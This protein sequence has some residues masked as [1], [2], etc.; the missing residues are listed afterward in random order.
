MSALPEL[1]RPAQAALLF[2]THDLTAAQAI[3]HRVA[4]FD[5]GHC[6][7]QAGF[8]DFLAAPAPGTPQALYR[9]WRESLPET[10]DAQ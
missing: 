4:V 1:L 10:P 5:E 7:Q 8:A 6:V 3:A 9:A 2:I